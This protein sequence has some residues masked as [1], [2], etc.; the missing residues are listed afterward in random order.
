MYH[1]SFLDTLSHWDTASL[2]AMRWWIDTSNPLLVSFIQIGWE[3]IVFVAVL[4][5]VLYW[6]SGTF[7]SDPVLK[8]NALGIF[9]GIIFSFGLYA[10]LNFFLIPQ[11]RMSPQEVAGAIAPI[12]NHP[13]DNS[14]PSGHAIFSGSFLVWILIFWIKRWIVSLMGIVI[15]VTLVSRVIGGVHY[16][17][18]IV[19]WL[20]L[21]V[22]AA[23]LFHLFIFPQNWFQQYA[24]YPL[25]RFASFFHL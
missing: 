25:L 1:M 7:T 18:D 6:L 17:W 14:F 10:I 19:G 23:L 12:I 4:F 2:I 16:P 5:L 9:Y 20:F 3:S 8:K 24:V 15:I 21:W 22:F 11:F 13:L